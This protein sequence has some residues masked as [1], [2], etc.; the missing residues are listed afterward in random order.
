MLKHHEN[1]S[2]TNPQ[3]LCSPCSIAK[4]SVSM[5]NMTLENEVNNAARNNDI[6]GN[7]MNDNMGE[8]EGKNWV[9]GHESARHNYL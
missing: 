3:C 2:L 8:A 4:Q 1:Q 6:Q 9:K 7:Q 5:P